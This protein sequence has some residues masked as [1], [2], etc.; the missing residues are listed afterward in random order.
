MEK[1]H[2]TSANVTFKTNPSNNTQWQVTFFSGGESYEKFAA[3]FDKNT[4]LMTFCDMGT[5]LDKSVTI[6]GEAYGGKCQGMS[7]TYGDK[8]RFVAF[9]VAIGDNG[10]LN[11]PEAEEFCKKLGIDFVPYR[12]VSTDLKSL[13]AERDL[14]SVQAVKNGI[15]TWV[16]GES[17]TSLTNLRKREGVVL[18]P[19]I[20][21]ITA[22]GERIITKHKG[23]D[24][25]E[26]TSPRVVDDPAKLQ[27]LADADKIA[28]E[29]ITVTR[30]EHVLDKIQK[31]DGYGMEI[32]PQLMK[33]MVEDVTR[34]AAG[35]IV[36]NEAVRKAITKKTATMFKDYLKA[37]LN[38]K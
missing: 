27:V 7:A 11:V 34:E 22:T 32:M 24:F 33:A 5:P 35:E 9:D 10:W 31:K 26:T 6:Y 30:L 15:S 28:T 12:K 14:H 37:K 8:L 36:D 20:E 17:V 25:R 38:G 3:L 2:G 23:D 19:L 13:D 18:R 4:L 1:I 21:L 16:D 29:W